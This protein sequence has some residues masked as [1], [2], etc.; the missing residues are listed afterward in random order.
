MPTLRR[1][2]AVAD[3]HGA[4]YEVERR[5]CAWISIDVDAD[6]Y[7]KFLVNHGVSFLTVQDPDQ[8][9]S[10]LYGTHGWPETY[11]IDRDG[12]VR[13]KFIGPVDWNAREIHD[14]LERL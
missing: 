2:N 11:I 10:S 12:V 7:H 5:D 1:R 9:T 13:R 3:Q 14:Y 8:K 6:A 4:K